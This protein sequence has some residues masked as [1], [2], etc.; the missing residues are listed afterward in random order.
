MRSTRA[1]TLSLP[2]C[3]LFPLLSKK[4]S[5]LAG[6]RFAVVIDE[7]HSSQTGES[8]RSLKQVL[9]APD[10]EKAENE[11]K[12][13]ADGEDA[14]NAAIEAQMRRRGQLPNVSYFAFT[15][16]PKNKTLELF[17]VRRPGGGF[18]PFALRA[19]GRTTVV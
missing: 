9:D 3:R 19:F 16:T 17:G 4:I 10:L 12:A 14:I 8:T 7:A 6:Q 2:H 5:T 11:D 15:A 1:R 18:A 13:E